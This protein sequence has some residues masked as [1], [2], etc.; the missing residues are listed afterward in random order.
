[1]R[2]LF[3]IGCSANYLLR[4][5]RGIQ[6]DARTSGGDLTAAG[7]AGDVVLRS[8]AGDVDVSD[9]S[10]RANLN[11]SAGNVVARDLHS[12]EVDAT[13]SAGDVELRFAGAPQMIEADSSAGDVN[14]RLPN[15]ADVY[16]VNASASAG[17][18]TTDVRTDPSSDRRLEL[19][20]SAGDVTVVYSR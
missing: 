13:S 19:R 11:S 14:L 4:V 3:A 7:L 15:G 5:P 1:V 12:T 17:D 20:S 8:S 16:Q 9:L 18:V 10:G 2:I 6:V